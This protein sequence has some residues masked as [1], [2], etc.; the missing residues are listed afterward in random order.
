MGINNA[1]R[2]FVFILTYVGEIRGGESGDLHLK[3]QFHRVASSTTEN[4][5]STQ[6]IKTTELVN[7]HVCESDPFA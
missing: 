2:I 3:G 6:T 1:R 7:P 5:F 4:N